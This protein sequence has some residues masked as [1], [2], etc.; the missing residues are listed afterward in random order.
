[1]EELAEEGD[2]GIADGIGDFLHSA[3][4]V[5]E[6]TFGGGDAELL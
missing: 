5:F 6:K 4:I 3:V 2:I 1:M